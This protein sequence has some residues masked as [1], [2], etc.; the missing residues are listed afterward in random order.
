ML[1][2]AR[3]CCAPSFFFCVFRSVLRRCRG[4]KRRTIITTFTENA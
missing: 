4:V 2:S 3:Q 1:E